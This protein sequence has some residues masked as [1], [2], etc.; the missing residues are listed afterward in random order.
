MREI[1]GGEEDSVAPSSG[2]RGRGIGSSSDSDKVGSMRSWAISKSRRGE[3]S[4][5]S[6]NGSKRNSGGRTLQVQ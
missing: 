3:I 5:D 6:E 1:V 4:S 2:K